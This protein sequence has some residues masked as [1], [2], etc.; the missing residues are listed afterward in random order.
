M[1][2]LFFMPTE[3]CHHDDDDEE[4]DDDYKKNTVKINKWCKENVLSMVTSETDTT[5]SMLVLL[6]VSYI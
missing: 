3:E 1:P 2:I 4:E 5:S 6:F